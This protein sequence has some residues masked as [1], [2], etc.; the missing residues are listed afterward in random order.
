MPRKK[1]GVLQTLLRSLLVQN[2]SLNAFGV[3]PADVVIEPDV[4]G[5]DLSEFVRAKELAAAGE[6]AALEQ[7]PK[8]RQ[9]LNRL[10]PQLFPMPESLSR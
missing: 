1:P 9:L 2:H 4:R 8:V 7:I 3:S 6:A 10:D 5:F